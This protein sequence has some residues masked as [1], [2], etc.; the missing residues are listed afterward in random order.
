MKVPEKYRIKEGQFA[1][2]EWEDGNNGN[3][4]IPYQ[5]FQ[6]TVI[7]SDGYGWDHVSVSLRNRC[8]NWHEMSYIKDLFFDDEETVVQFHPKKSEYVDNHPNCLHLWKKQGMSPLNNFEHELPPAILVGFK[9]GKDEN[10]KGTSG[11]D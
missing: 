7:A 10:T 4:I 5:S 9:G 1:S 2:S 8:P 6:L 3:F 11:S